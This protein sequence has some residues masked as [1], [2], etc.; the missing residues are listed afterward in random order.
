MAVCDEHAEKTLAPYFVV[1]GS[2]ESAVE[3]LPLQSNSAE[4]RI[5]GVIADVKVTQVY[6]NSG[7]APIEALYVFPGSTRA[8][9]YG[10]RMVIGDR[11][12]EAKIEERNEAKATY[13][14]A[15]RAGKS[16]SLLE[17]HRP[18]V[19][20]MSVANIMPGDEV[21]VEL[22]YTELLIPTDGDYEFVYPT[23]V[24][25]RYSNT[26]VADAPA[27]EQWVSNPY[28]TEG[29][30]APYT[31]SI[32]VEIDGAVPLQEL[33]SPSHSIDPKFS[34][35][36][37]ASV[38]LTS[39]E[40]YRG[41]KD[42]I[43]KYRLQGGAIQTGMLLSEQNGEKFFLMMA[44]PPHRLKDYEIPRRNYT[45]VVDVSGSMN[46]FPLT[47]TKR[48]MQELASKLRPNDSFN[49]ILF[50][51]A[52]Q[53][54]FGSPMPATEGNIAHAVALIDNQRA[55]GATD[56]IT[57]L[58][59]ALTQSAP[60]GAAN[61]IVLI[62]DG[63]VDVEREALELIGSNLDKTSLFTFGIGSSVNRYLI[64]ALAR[65]GQGESFIATSSEEAVAVAQRFRKYI[66]SPV[67][68]ALKVQ[69]TGLESYDVEPLV[70]PDMYA[71][72]PLLL[73]GKYR[74]HA[75]GT[76]KI[77]GKNGI[78]HFQQ[79]VTIQ[80]DTARTSGDGLRYLWARGRIA[81]LSDYATVAPSPKTTREVTR[82]G[83]QYNLLTQYTSFVA[84]DDVVRNTSGQSNTVK[85]PVPLPE[86]V[87]NAAVAG[88]GEIGT[89]P[90][91]ETWALLI[92]VVATLLVA[93]AS[94]KVRIA[95]A[96]RDAR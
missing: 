7:K 87:S 80:E 53:V 83:L 52:A 66:E 47:V 2:S 76:A 12:R 89:S 86:G 6:R 45:F 77:T 63:Y 20:Q 29:N 44:Q 46:G 94:S 18:N 68:T 48:L 74:G 60:E 96:G 1:K 50:A 5:A 61:S 92:L 93:A 28:L 37:K 69:F 15:K 71:D 65:A 85:Q 73:F 4:V 81:R 36:S 84:V 54:L 11:I 35:P 67:L 14:A 9:V 25:P 22:R 70:I 8:A 75:H 34:S 51:G 41:N 43:L 82:L 42:F 38:R 40:E 39:G 55:G 32:A 57:A 56:L 58:R 64:E 26:D 95:I 13:D 78:T 24:G 91:P 17:Q 3:S 31:T 62:T 49:V 19:F 33:T 10:M 30:Q 90:E 27:S 59:T 79:E 23:V 88:F 72:R 16:A 21:R